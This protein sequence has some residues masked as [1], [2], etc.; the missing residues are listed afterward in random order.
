MDDVTLDVLFG[1]AKRMRDL[2][3][4][5]RDSIWAFILKNVYKPIFLKNQFDWILGNPPWLSFRYVEKGEYQDY[6]RNAILN[7]YGLLEKGQ[8]HLI[9]HLELGTL[10]FCASLYQY[11]KKGSR[12]GFVLPRSIFTA[13]QHHNFRATTFG[14][15]I[16]QTGITEIWDLE[17]VS[18][19]FNVPSCVVFGTRPLLTKKPIYTEVLSGELNKEKRNV[20]LEEAKKH[21][22]IRETGLYVVRQGERSFWSEDQ[23]A[24]YTGS[25][26]YASKFAEG[27]TLVPRSC[28]FVD[29]K[30]DGALGF[31]P[32][33]PLV[34]T[35]PRATEQAKEAYED[36]ILEGNIE[37]EFLYAT[38][39]STDL[40]P[41]GFLDYRMVVLPIKPSGQNFVMITEGYAKKEG[42]SHLAKWLNN[43]ESEWKRRRRGKASKMN[44]YER[45]NHV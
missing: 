27:A 24:E 16:H 34:S 9:T 40:L 8:G 31:N 23:K 11:G 1:V 21:I 13:D 29:V 3:D 2:I 4:K 20:S 6:L 18:P 43:C 45:L 14:K 15:T 25:S 28:W 12:I 36:L 10:V 22:S 19:L 39:L 38:L 42:W 33:T 35:D 5:G 17:K 44:I 30:T 37:K 41:F 26:P 7:A 32:A